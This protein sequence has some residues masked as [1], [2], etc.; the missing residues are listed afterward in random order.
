M[1]WK[2][3]NGRKLSSISMKNVD[4]ML[5]DNWKDTNSVTSG[6]GCKMYPEKC[7]VETNWKANKKITTTN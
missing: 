5:Y 4:Y 7:S 2:N 6:K 1:N 3:W